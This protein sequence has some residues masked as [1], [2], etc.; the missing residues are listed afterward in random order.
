MSYGK[1]AA[2]GAGLLSGV[3]YLS[4]TQAETEFEKRGYLGLGVGISNLDPDTDGTSFSVDDKR[5]IGAKIFLGYDISERF[6]LEGYYSHLGKAEITPSGSLKYK[7]FGVSGLYYFYKQHLP[8]VGWGAFGR[9]GLGRM[10]NDSDLNY[11]R[12]HD[13]HIMLGAGM[14]YGFNNG[15]ALRGDVDFYD[16]DA[17]L[18]AINLLKRFG[19]SKKQRAIVAPVAMLD[20]DN[21]GIVD[22]ED[23]CPQTPIGVSVDD[24]GCELDSDFDGIVDSQDRCPA[25]PNTVIV[26]TQGCERDSD[27]DGVADS[28]DRCLA[29]PSGASVNDRGCEPDSDGDGVADNHDRCP[30]TVTGAEVDARGCEID[31]D[32]DGIVDRLDRCPGTASGVKVDA[33][34]CKL[35]MVFVL[36]GVTFATASA[37][38]IG[39]SL[40]VLNE[41]RDTL[42]LHPEIKV[43]VAGYTDSRGARKYNVSLSQRRADAV[44]RYLIEQGISADRLIAKGYGPDKPIADNATS[45]GRAANRRVEMRILN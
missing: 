11:S 35:K 10:I 22:A 12:D 6:S 2:L 20:G 8:H 28:Q 25:T 14:E 4:T 32:N 41:V 17:R 19:G 29:T 30:E 44:R 27:G 7:D 15:F 23:V 26:D 37:E 3:L 13:N 43:E 36:K 33:Q 39:D 9:L 1:L 5:D 40:K 34:G 24:K 42:Q 18:L 45:A 16:K 38:L 21:D 31:A